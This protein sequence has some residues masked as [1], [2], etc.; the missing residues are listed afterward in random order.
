MPFKIHV[1]LEEGYVLLDHYDEISVAE[2]NEA[3]SN[4]IE[5]LVKHALSRVLVNIC[6]VTNKL[7]TLDTYF[8]TESHA[9][10]KLPKARAALLS[11][12]DQREDA[13]FMETVA[14]NRGLNIRSFL[15]KEEA[16]AW[17]QS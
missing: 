9:K 3:R 13:K 5:Q 17:L 7:S 8:V 1:F 2:V 16:L 14:V 4:V 6:D 11:R 10:V 12:P 15:N